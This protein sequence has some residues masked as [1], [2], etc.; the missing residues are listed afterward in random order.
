MRLLLDEHF[1][2]QIAR[3]LR[4]QGY[5][6]VAAR[7]RDDLHGLSDRDLLLFARHERRVIV[8]ENV[9]DFMEL[10]REALVRGDRHAGLVFTSPKAFPRTRRAIR[11]TVRAL[12]KLLEQ[13]PDP[14]PLADQVWWL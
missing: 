8:T 10:H 11:R 3:Q 4:I 6:V 1:S 9:A 14:N 12:A 5:D 13:H 2:P 7:E